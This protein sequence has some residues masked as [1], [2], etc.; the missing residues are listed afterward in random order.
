MTNTDELDYEYEQQKAE[1]DYQRYLKRRGI[2]EAEHEQ[3][4]GERLD[5]QD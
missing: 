4:I 3:E 2:T 5:A 1:A